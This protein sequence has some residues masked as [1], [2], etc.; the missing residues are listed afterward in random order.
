MPAA[1]YYVVSRTCDYCI[2]F[3]K[4][5]HTHTHTHICTHTHTYIHTHTY[6]YTHTHTHTHTHT[7]NPYTYKKDEQRIVA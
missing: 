4:Y 1:P 7:F 6:M 3:K 5:T 2:F